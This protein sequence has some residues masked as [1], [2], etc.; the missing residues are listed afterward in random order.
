M[1]S[2][3]WHGLL[4]SIAMGMALGLLD[5]VA[6]FFTARAFLRATSPGTRIGPVAWEIARLALII[7]VIIFLARYHIF[8]CW[9]LLITVVLVSLV[10]KSV[11][12]FRKL[13]QA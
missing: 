1:S 8:N 7:A 10:G 9:W 5:T 4:A 3:A 13:K 11:L 2:G 6:F 12:A